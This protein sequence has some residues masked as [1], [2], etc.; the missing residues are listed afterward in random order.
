MVVLNQNTPI[1][2]ECKAG[3]FKVERNNV[4]YVVC[5]DCHKTYEVLDYGTAG[6]EIVVSDDILE[7]HEY[8]LGQ[9]KTVKESFMSAVGLLA[10]QIMAE[11]GYFKEEEE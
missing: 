3:M 4:L 10:S 5:H 8:R 6:N 9:D 7:I 1:C 11:D 2:P